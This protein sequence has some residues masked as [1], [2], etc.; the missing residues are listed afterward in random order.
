MAPKLSVSEGHRK[1][2]EAAGRY[3]VEFV[4]GRRKWTK[5]ADVG[6]IYWLA[7]W[8]GHWGRKSLGAVN[9]K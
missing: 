4:L 5:G 3:C 6:Y 1:D 7:R 2:A 8:A 9:V